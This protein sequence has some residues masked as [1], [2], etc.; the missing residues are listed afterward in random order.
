MH[1]DRRRFQK[2]VF[3]YDTLEVLITVTLYP[4]YNNTNPHILWKSCVVFVFQDKIEKTAP[5]RYTHA[6]LKQQ[7]STFLIIV[8]QTNEA[9]NENIRG[10]N[11]EWNRSICSTIP[12]Y[13][14]YISQ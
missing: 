3:F 12:A 10:N 8:G 2:K 13:I 1:L 14:N 7:R 11:E 4:R 9:L 5:L 6:V